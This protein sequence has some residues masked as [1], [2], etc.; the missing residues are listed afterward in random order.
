MNNGK[1]KME[2]G[3]WILADIG[4]THYHI[5][6]KGKIYDLKESKKFDGKIYYISV[7]ETKEKE[8]LNLNPKAVNLKNYVK[9][10]TDYKNLGID[11]IMASLS[12]KTGTVIDA[13]SAVTVD[14]MK[15]GRHLGGVI[16][17]GIFAYKKAFVTISD[18][19]N[20]NLIKPANFPSSTEE[21]LWCGSI[22]SIKCIVEK[23]NIN[24]VYLTGGD[25]KYLSEFINGIYIKD[26]VFRGMKKVIIEN[27]EEK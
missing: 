19:L 23:Y 11:R 18:K 3:K 13:G 6:D 15:N 8:F 1:W 12:I 20:K 14:F 27:G 24:P 25:G 7:N 26:L 17:P 2:N 10:D 22:G 16:F 5:W 4:N 9:F 21:A